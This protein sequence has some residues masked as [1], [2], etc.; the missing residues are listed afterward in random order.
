MARRVIRYIGDSED[1]LDKLQK[2][3]IQHGITIDNALGFANRERVGSTRPLNDNIFHLE[4]GSYR[5]FLLERKINELV[6]RVNKCCSDDNRN[7]PIATPII[8]AL[9]RPVYRS[10]PSTNT[11]RRNVRNNSLTQEASRRIGNTVLRRTNNTGTRRNTGIPE[12]AFLRMGEVLHQN[13]GRNRD[14]R[15]SQQQIDELDDQQLDK[16]HGIDIDI[17]S[18]LSLDKL[19][20]PNVSRRTFYSVKKHIDEHRTFKQTNFNDENEVY[21]NMTTIRLIELISQ[22]L[23]T[24][25]P[26]KNLIF[27][28][29]EILRR[30]RYA[31]RKKFKD[32]KR[33]LIVI[34]NRPELEKEYEFLKKKSS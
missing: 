33:G 9:A 14:M 21:R 25:T 13:S 3:A 27:K 11:R 20:P 28:V 24:R 19:L 18:L 29:V 12:E 4:E 7:V 34:E 5:L 8:S 6:D 15:M 31:I 26:L 32:E 1:I 30:K 22:D 17:L 16:L 2:G 23:I 10:E